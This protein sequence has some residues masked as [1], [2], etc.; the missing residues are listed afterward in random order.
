ML[1]AQTEIG[2]NDLHNWLMDRKNRRTLPHRLAS[3]GYMP[4]PSSSQ[5]G[6]WIIN[7]R[8]QMIYGRHDLAP[9]LRYAVAVALKERLEQA[10]RVLPTSVTPL[11]KR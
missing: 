11:K 1:R 6:L 8:R 3:C 9:A 2:A 10:A 4:V 5:D 7:G